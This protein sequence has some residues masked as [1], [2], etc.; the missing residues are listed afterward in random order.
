MILIIVLSVLLAASVTGNFMLYNAANIQLK[1][2]E[3]YEKSIEDFYENLTLVLT[4]IRTIDEKEMFE[5][6]DEVG[7]VFDQIV[8]TINELRPLLYGAND[9]ENEKER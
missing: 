5:S 3:I 7:T 1:K 9:A 6:D 8:E 4:T 2:N